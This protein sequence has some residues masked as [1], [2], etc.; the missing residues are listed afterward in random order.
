MPG[1]RITRQQAKVYMT[2]RKSG[3][4]QTICSTKAGFSSRSGRSIERMGVTAF[5][6]KKQSSKKHSDPLEG[7]WES[8]LVPLLE[9]TPYLTSWT[10]LEHLQDQYPGNIQIP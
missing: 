2:L 1:K 6:Q 5:T 7:L 3:L 9:Q 4:N 10:L 8:V